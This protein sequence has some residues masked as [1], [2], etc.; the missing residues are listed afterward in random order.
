MSLSFTSSLE[1]VQWIYQHKNLILYD[2]RMG[3]QQKELFPENWMLNFVSMQ[4]SSNWPEEGNGFFVSA[5]C[6]YLPFKYPRIK[7]TTCFLGS[8]NRL[9]IHQQRFYNAYI[10]PAIEL[11]SYQLYISHVFCSVL[12]VWWCKIEETPTKFQGKRW[13]CDCW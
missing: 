1:V 9:N 12:P 13:Y 4:T 8:Y 6:Q 10:Y 2:E 3:M 5:V 11:Q 7:E